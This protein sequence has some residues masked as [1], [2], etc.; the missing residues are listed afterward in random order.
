MRPRRRR[1]FAEADALAQVDAAEAPCRGRRRVGLAVEG[2]IEGRDRDLRL[3]LGDRG[4]DC[5]GRGVFRESGALKIPAKMPRRGRERDPA[6]FLPGREPEVGGVDGQRDPAARVRDPAHH[7]VG[8]R[9]RVPI[10]SPEDRVLFA[11]DGPRLPSAL[12]GEEL[13]HHRS[14][15]VFRVEPDVRRDQAVAGHSQR[16]GIGRG[17][18]G[19]VL[20]ERIPGGDRAVEGAGAGKH[21]ARHI[22]REPVGIRR[23]IPPGREVVVEPGDASGI[24][25][26]IVGIGADEAIVVGVGA[27]V[28]M[29]GG[30]EDQPRGE[31]FAVHADGGAGSAVGQSVVR[32]GRGG[33]R[34]RR[35]GL[36]DR[37]GDRAGGARVVRVRACE[38][39]AIDVGA[40]V[41]VARRDREPGGEIHKWGFLH[42][43]VAT[44]DRASGR[45]GLSVVGHRVRS[46]R[47][48][49]I[50][51]VDRRR[52]AP[53]LV[54]VVGIGA[55]EVP[56][57][58]IAAGI[59]VEL[60]GEVRPQPL[61]V[62]RVGV[63]RSCAMLGAI[64]R[65]IGIGAVD[66]RMGLYDD[67]RHRP[68]GV[69]IVGVV[70]RER[71]GI[72]IGAGL[73]MGRAEREAAGQCCAI[74]P[75][76]GSARQGTT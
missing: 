7:E 36:A 67:V 34:D 31:I 44:G 22:A 71:P 23:E 60:V 61:P 6:D 41:G 58:E 49:R 27:G 75:L 39:P 32:R 56:G 57:V 64:V 12:V 40:S 65:R 1:R 72:L 73:G 19:D 30:I 24:D 66:L 52:D 17:H 35:G 54:G 3:P 43:R 48:R 38:G 11:P 69:L 4:D 37:A 9:H 10:L 45:V 13:Q 50:R 18:R 8:R 28:D 33:D 21:L 16:P 63:E 14:R 59:A 51:L 26:G 62:E 42:L 68:R 29:L 25:V 74:D 70:G 5:R 47:H 2:E 15:L 76:R 20:A 46:D 53:R 55:C